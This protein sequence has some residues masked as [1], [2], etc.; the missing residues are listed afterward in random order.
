MVE[1]HGAE[2]P[3]PLDAGFSLIEVIV[4]MVLL[5]ILAVVTLPFFITGIRVTA[6]DGARTT[7]TD[8]VNAVLEQLRAKPDC[9]DLSATVTTLNQPANQTRYDARHRPF[10]VAVAAPVYSDGACAA[11]ATATV[12]VTATRDAATL[13]SA[14]TIIYLTS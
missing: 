1:R 4:A 11:K 13:S 9:A 6:D 10:K 3:A 2:Q 12:T 7:A 5:G 8:Q 14:T